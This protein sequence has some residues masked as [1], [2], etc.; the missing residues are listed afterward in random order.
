MHG[1]WTHSAHT[2]LNNIGNHFIFFGIAFGASSVAFPN[3]FC[4]SNFEH[5]LTDHN[6]VLNSENVLIEILISYKFEH[7]CSNDVNDRLCYLHWTDIFLFNL[8]RWLLFDLH[9][10]NIIANLINTF[11]VAWLSWRVVSVFLLIFSVLSH[12]YGFGMVNGIR[13][14][15]FDKSNFVFTIW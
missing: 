15:Y 10:A 3:N 5:I 2:A 1:T 6:L 4:N 9:F 8:L 14:F 7:F 12:L 13:N 11:C